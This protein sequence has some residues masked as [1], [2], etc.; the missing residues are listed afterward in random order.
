MANKPAQ[1]RVND[2]KHVSETYVD[3]L[4]IAEFRNGMPLLT[5]VV[6][7]AQT[8]PAKGV[9]TVLADEV[10]ARLLLSPMAAVKLKQFLDATIR[11]ED[12]GPISQDKA[13]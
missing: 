5:F 2:P 3:D 1:K 11:V 8:V 13:N 10:V 4:A 12:V 7:R 9:E 6:Q